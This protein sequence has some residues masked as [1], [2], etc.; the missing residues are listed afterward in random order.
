MSVQEIEAALEQMSPLE[1]R[2]LERSVHARLEKA[3]A[4][5]EGFGYGMRQYGMTRE[6]L[7]AFEKRQDAENREMDKKGLTVTFEGPFDPASLD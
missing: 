2:E 3:E 1:L 6:E 5:E 4:G 7:E